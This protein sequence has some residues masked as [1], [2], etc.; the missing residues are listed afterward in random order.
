MRRECFNCGG[1]ISLRTCARGLVVTHVLYLMT[2]V[3][4]EVNRHDED[5]YCDGIG[6]G[7]EGSR[8]SGGGRVVNKQ[9]AVAKPKH[10]CQRLDLE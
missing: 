5:M 2:V 7:L 3:N 4:F 10:H 9:C 6:L 1:A 8:R